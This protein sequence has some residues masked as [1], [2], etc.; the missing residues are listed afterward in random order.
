MRFLFSA[1]AIIK[2]QLYVCTIRTVPRDARKLMLVEIL[3]RIV[4]ARS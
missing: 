2:K 3:F 1:C 4:E